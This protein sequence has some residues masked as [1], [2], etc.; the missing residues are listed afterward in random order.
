MGEEDEADAA[1][2]G[3]R[4]ANRLQVPGV[5]GA[6]IDHHAG[7]GAEQIGVGPFQRH[8]P[9]VGGD[10]LQDLGMSRRL[11]H[12]LRDCPSYSEEN[13]GVA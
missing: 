6:R 2:P 7:I 10:D 5:V 3:R 9:R 11:S 1:A 13:F 12:R 4:G 8:R